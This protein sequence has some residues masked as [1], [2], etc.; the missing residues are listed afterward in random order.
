MSFFKNESGFTLM[1]ILVALTLMGITL[2]AFVQLFSGS[3]RT[4]SKSEYYVYAS[5][6]ADSAMREVMERTDL[7]VG[8]WSETDVEGYTIDVTVTEIEEERF[9]ELDEYRLLQIDLVLKW[10]QGKSERMIKLSSLQVA[11]NE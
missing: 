10:I 3:L 11:R 9:E 6:R 2:T 4:I 5:M 1:E 8:S 7:D